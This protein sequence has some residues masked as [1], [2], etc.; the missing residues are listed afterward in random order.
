[1]ISYERII[2]Y[3]N[4]KEGVK[5]MAC[6]HYYFKDKFKYQTYFCNKCHDFSMNVMNLSHFFILNIKGVDYRVY[7]SGIDKKEA[8]NIL[9]CIINGIYTKY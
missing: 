1:M 9:K 5:C 8:V 3:N 6:Q 2:G 4:G 7:I